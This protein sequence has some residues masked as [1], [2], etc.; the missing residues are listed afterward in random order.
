MR[1]VV[2]LFIIATI[3]ISC[4][5]KKQSTTTNVEG[6]IEE[7][8]TLM[9]GKFSSAEQAKADSAFY[10]ISLVM[11]PIWQGDANTK[12]LYVEQAVAQQPMKPYRQR[13]YKITAT[14]KAN[15]FESKVFTLPQPER[16]IHGWENTALFDQITP[17]SLIM[18]EGCSIFLTKTGDNCYEG[19][20]REKECKSQLYGATYATSTVEVCAGKVMSWDQGW[21]DVDV[22]VWGAVKSGYIFMKEAEF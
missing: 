15:V 16:F 1:K 2:T 18:R 3:A 5:S 20:T 17:D 8:H 11:F 7:L 10:N 12:W 4:S 14:Q 9:T 13:V 19:S 21:N 22:Q 6:S